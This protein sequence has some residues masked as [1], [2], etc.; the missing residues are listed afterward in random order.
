MKN[1]E[2][3][4]LP[5]IP[6]LAFFDVRGELLEGKKI[7]SS[8]LKKNLFF[9][10]SPSVFLGEEPFADFYM[11]W[12]RAG[13]SVRCEIKVPFEDCRYPRY[14]EGDSLELCFDTRDLKD[15]GFVHRF[16]HHFLILPQ[17]VQGVRALEITRFRTDDTHPLC[18]PEELEVATEFGKER[19]S[20]TLEIPSSCLHG[21]DPLSLDHIG[22]T[23]RI[24]R[25]RGSSQHFALSS[26]REQFQNHPALWS[27]LK[28]IK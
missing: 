12:H 3:L 6:P 11:A 23:Y 9:L 10:S 21:Y 27:S 13:I 4:V 28:L 17:E 24:N 8:S 7:P 25:R 18:D 19:Y 22:F 1:L 5:S 16:C 20:M 26:H 2:D 15:V 14:E